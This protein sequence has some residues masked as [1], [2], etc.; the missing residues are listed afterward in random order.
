M[1]RLYRWSVREYASAA[2]RSAGEGSRKGG[3]DGGDDGEARQVMRFLPILAAVI[4]SACAVAA[5]RW[6]VGKTAD[7]CW[8]ED[9]C[10]LYPPYLSTAEYCGEPRVV[11]PWS[12]R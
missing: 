3:D 2:I 8:T 12:R 11:C 7:G 1:R 6:Q 10:G 5:P 9:G 4:L